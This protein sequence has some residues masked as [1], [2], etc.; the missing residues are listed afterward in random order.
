MDLDERNFKRRQRAAVHRYTD[1][2][3]DAIL[4]KTLDGIREVLNMQ[5]SALDAL[6]LKIR[7]IQERL[8]INEPY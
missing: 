4:R 7:I 1:G 3:V 5:N 6:Q 2:D 8:K